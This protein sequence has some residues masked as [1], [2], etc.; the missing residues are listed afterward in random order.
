[1]ICR[2]SLHDLDAPLF[3]LGMICTCGALRKKL[4]VQDAEF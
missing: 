4:R 1:M 3:D 2:Q